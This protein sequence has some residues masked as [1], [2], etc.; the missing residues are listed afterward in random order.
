MPFRHL[1][2]LATGLLV[3]SWIVAGRAGT[4]SL[5]RPARDYFARAV[6]ETGQCASNLAANGTLPAFRGNSGVITFSVKREVA[7]AIRAYSRQ[8]K[9]ADRKLR[10]HCAAK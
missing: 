4:S 5:T 7:R 10:R 2:S 3:V 9:I 6:T 1:A 8:I